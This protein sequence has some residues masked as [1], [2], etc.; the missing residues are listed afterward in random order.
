MRAGTNAFRLSSYAS[1]LTNSVRNAII[2]GLENNQKED[3]FAKRERYT[4]A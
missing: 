1:I 3:S 2:I 4:F